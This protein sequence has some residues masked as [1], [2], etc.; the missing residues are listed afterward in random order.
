MLYVISKTNFP[1]NHLTDGKPGLNQIKSN[2]NK[3]TSRS[4]MAERPRDACSSTV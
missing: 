2:W 4:A 1:G 3:F